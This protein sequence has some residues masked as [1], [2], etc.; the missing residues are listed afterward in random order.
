M[1]PSPLPDILAEVQLKLQHVSMLAQRLVVMSA[2]SVKDGRATL[3]AAEAAIAVIAR[4][5]REQRDRA[6]AG[7]TPLDRF[8]SEGTIRH[9]HGRPEFKNGGV[10]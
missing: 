8:P 7:P 4:Y 10:R 3:A 1:K 2:Q 9:D 6:A 5:E